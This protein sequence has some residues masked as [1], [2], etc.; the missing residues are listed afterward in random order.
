MDLL[1]CVLLLLDQVGI[2]CINFMKSC[3]VFIGWDVD[4]KRLV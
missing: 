1:E 4:V 2:Y 3:Y